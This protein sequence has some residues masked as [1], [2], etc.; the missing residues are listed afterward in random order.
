MSNAFVSTCAVIFCTKFGHNK[1]CTFDTE[2]FV[3]VASFW[4]VVGSP[5]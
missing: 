3:S 2:G 1:T 4:G 5:S